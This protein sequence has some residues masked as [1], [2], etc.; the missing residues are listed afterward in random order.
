VPPATW[1]LSRRLFLAGVALVYGIAFASLGVQVQG[2]FG[3]Q[4]IVPLAELLDGARERVSWFDA[5]SLLWW[6]AGDVWLSCWCW[7]GVALAAL[8]LLGILPRLT[9]GALWLL[10]L[11]FTS[12]GS[13]FLNFQWD[14]LL[15]EAGLLAVAWAPDGW[16]PFGRRERPPS[17][18]LR[19][20]VYGLLFKL[21]LLS[22]IVKLTSGDDS[23]RDGSAL[24]FHFWTQPL[25]HRWSV[26]VDDLPAWT[27]RLS[28]A[29]M[30]AIELGVPLLLLVPWKRRR[31][32]QVVAAAT[33]ALMLVI[34]LT[35]NYGFF[36]LLTAVL[37]LPLLDDRAWSRVPGL[38]ARARAE[39]PGVPTWRRV[40]TGLFAA[41]IGLLSVE[42]F[43]GALRVSLPL[44]GPLAALARAAAP[45][46][47]CNAYGLFRV[48]TQERPEILVEGSADGQTW[49]P[50]GFRYK[51]LELERPPVF[52]GLHMP[53]LDWQLWFEALGYQSP[54]R[55]RWFDAFLER[56][57]EGSPP[58]LDLLRE[59]PFP[60]GPPQLVRARLAF[61]RFATPAERERGLW[62]QRDE[63]RELAPARRR[64]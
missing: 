25:P 14:V 27:H 48:M 9:L 47:S 54:W 61:Y 44:P 34:F 28:T 64:R 55:D 26:L 41:T 60:D 53:R 56:L 19:W 21:M 1:F 59:N 50:Y 2:L 40:V 38:R 29:V 45:F 33:T 37:C 5:P 39:P 52:A 31:L 36:N 49:K 3:S 63:P 30:F 6:H 46:Q 57:L 13:P 15:L 62:W 23:W 12:V 24:D 58:V 17:D 18:A 4:G 35:G 42:R 10:Y 32:R 22:G 43:C 11:S 8:A 16:R 51:P 7:T 20:L